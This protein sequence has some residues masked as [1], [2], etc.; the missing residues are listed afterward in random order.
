MATKVYLEVGS[1]KVFACALDWPGWARSGKDEEAAL[2]NLAAYAS[3]YAP[4]AAKADARFPKNAG[5]GFEIVERMRGSGATDFGVLDKPAAADNKPLTKARA[6]RLAAIVEAAWQVFDAV[7]ARAP[8]EL[9]KGP[10]GGGRDRDKIVE[11]VVGAEV[12]YARMI[13]LRFKESDVADAA[14]VARVRGEILAALRSARAAAPDLETKVWPYR[15]AARRFAW[16]VL[17]HAWEM[18]DRSS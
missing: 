2:A 15:Y 1:K 14:G 9:R 5:D 10:R 18:E 16:H 8:A 3:R 12:A 4:V 13:G 11:H 17:D 7:A 6:Q